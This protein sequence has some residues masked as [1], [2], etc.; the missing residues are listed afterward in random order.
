LFLS[1][2]YIEGQITFFIIKNCLFVI[3]WIKSLY[4]ILAWGNASQCHT[5]RVESLQIRMLKVVMNDVKRKTILTRKQIFSFCN[6][7]PVSS[8]F[9]YRLLVEF[10]YKPD[11]KIPL[12][13]CRTTRLKESGTLKW[14]VFINKYGSSVSSMFNTLP[15]GIK[16]LSSFT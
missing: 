12:D 3:S 5:Q 9:K 16:T 1:V 14:P 15:L 4:G 13:T 6:V 2:V 11:F 8:L 10:Y 7:L